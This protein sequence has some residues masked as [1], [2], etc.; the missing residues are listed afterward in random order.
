MRSSIVALI[1]LSLTSPAVAEVYTTGSIGASMITGLPPD[2][3]WHQDGLP[4]EINTASLAYKVGVGYQF[5]R[6]YVEANYLKMGTFNTDAVWVPDADYDPI[7][8]AALTRCRDAHAVMHSTLHAGELVVG[9]QYPL[10][11]LISARIHAGVWGGKHH[12]TARVSDDHATWGGPFNG[13]QLGGTAGVGLCAGP[14]WQVC[15]EVS[16]YHTVSETRFAVAKDVTMPTFT[17][18][19]PIGGL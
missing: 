11:D 2:G 9:Y 18:K 15:G 8:H 5:S 4:G 17:I 10:S 3:T 12:I 6:W 19:V 14:S 7:H 13:M 1:L 16:H